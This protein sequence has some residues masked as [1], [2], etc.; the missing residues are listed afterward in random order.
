MGHVNHRTLALA[1][2]STLVREAWPDYTP[3]FNAVTYFNWPGPSLYL[4]PNI[5]PKLAPDGA[6]TPQQV[7]EALCARGA[8]PACSYCIVVTEADLETGA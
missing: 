3:P 8:I 7:L 2:L 4:F 6:F 5:T 1:Q